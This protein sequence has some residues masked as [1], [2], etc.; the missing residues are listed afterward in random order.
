MPE[1]VFEEL[2]RYVKFDGAD[3]DA[4]RRFHPLAAPH[5][6]R[7]AEGFY[8]RILSHEEAP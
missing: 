3:E 4:L 1:T 6:Q 5:F 7:V 2:R 8:D